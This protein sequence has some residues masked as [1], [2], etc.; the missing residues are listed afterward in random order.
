MLEMRL[1]SLAATALTVTVALALSAQEAQSPQWRVSIRSFG[2]VRIGMTLARAARALGERLHYVDVEEGC[3]HVRPRT[4]PPGTSFM[5]VNGRIARVDVDSGDVA[6]LSGAHIGSTEA[7]V[8]HLYPGQIRVEPHPYTGPEGHYLV[9]L[10]R[11]TVDSTFGMIFET[12]GR[13]VTSYRAGLRE[14]VQYIEGCL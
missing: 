10:P 9:F 11:D 6:T 5:V 7:E 1:P 8:Q 4:A 13:R 12:D 3:G 14:P 2:P